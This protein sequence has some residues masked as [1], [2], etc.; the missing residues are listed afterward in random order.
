MKWLLLFVM[1]GFLMALS[2]ITQTHDQPGDLENELR[3][4]FTNAQDRHFN[5]FVATPTLQNTLRYEPFIVGNATNTVF[6]CFSIDNTTSTYWCVQMSS[7]T[8]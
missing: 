1:C 5:F 7:R 6:F 4:I 8:R 3:N 2:P